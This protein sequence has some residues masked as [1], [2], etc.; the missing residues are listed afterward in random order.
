MNQ[1]QTAEAPHEVASPTIS[2][3]YKCHHCGKPIFLRNSVCLN[4]GSPV[5][6]DPS[7]RTMIS[8]A[9]VA[10]TPGVFELVDEPGSRVMTCANLTTAAGCSW[11]I[12][13]NAQGGF[14]Y[15][16]QYPGFCLACSLNRTVP[17]Q[18]IP[19]NQELWRRMEIPK[20][21]LVS[22]L[23][24]LALPV[25]TRLERHDGIAFDFLE[26]LPGGPRVMTGHDSGLITMNIQEADDAAREKLRNDMHEPYRTLLGHFRH[27]IGH[28]YWGRLV[29]GGPLLGE[30]RKLF[31]DDST[32]YEAAL[33]HHYAEGPPADWALHFISGYAAAHP[34]E[35]W[36]ETWAHYL[37]MCDTVDTALSF[38]INADA[39]DMQAVPYEKA[40]LWQPEHENAEAFLAFLNT[41]V[42]LT[43]VL[44]E[45]SRAM[46]QPDYYPF[47]LPH[48]AV[49]KLQF[50]H[51]VV[52]GASVIEPVV[53][54]IPQV[55]QP[56]EVAPAA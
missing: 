8:L 48:A 31:G 15:P 13:A 39:V 11:L 49:G 26:S 37:H 6:Y 55:E 54:P 52:R 12:P 33:Q 51:E 47:I 16:N 38:A 40:D 4:C 10:E 35:D 32:D 3:A 21:R 46:G 7:R 5:G 30:C 56:V 27:E 42:R 17:D 34:Y 1:S 28:Y 43:N 45:L 29:E 18:S 14:D 24:A 53:N 23:L 19:D 22:Q 41:W 36:A 25:E 20:R 2:R 9:P 44:N 50:I